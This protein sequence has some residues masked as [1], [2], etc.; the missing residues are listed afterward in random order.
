M[1]IKFDFVTNS[2]STCFVVVLKKGQEFT[3]IQFMKCVGINKKSPVY[4]MF[5]ELFKIFASNMEPFDAAVASH[6]WNKGS[7]WDVFISHVFSADLAEKIKLAKERGDSLY[8][9]TLSSDVNALETFVCCDSF[10]IEGKNIYIDATNSR[11]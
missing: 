6:R 11:W 4:P 5:L 2:S 8:F 1:K 10:K 7:Q 9:G 3:E